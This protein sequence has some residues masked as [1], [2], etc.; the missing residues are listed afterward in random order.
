MRLSALA[1]PALAS[2]LAAS[3]FSL[4]AQ[5]APS[6]ADQASEKK[7]A[8]AAKNSFLKKCE[9]E[10]GPSDCAAQAAEKKL[11]GAARTSFLKKC[12]AGAA[13]SPAPQA[14]CQAQA[15]G[16]KLAGAARSS[17]VKKCVAD[18]AAK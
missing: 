1:R 15:D 13:P 16:K 10:A 2:F 3:L 4:G 7:L 14:A 11:A 17:F 18:A 12:E 9:R 8:G 6:C 5:A